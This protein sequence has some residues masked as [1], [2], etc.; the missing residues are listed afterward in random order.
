MAKFALK[1]VQGII[2]RETITLNL[3]KKWHMDKNTLLSVDSGFLFDNESP[4]NLREELGIPNDQMFIGITT[5]NWLS[6]GKQEKYER[7]VAEFSDYAIRTYNAAII[8][9]PQVTVENRKDDDRESNKRA[10]SYMKESERAYILTERYGHGTI[11]AI[12]ENLDYLIG[13]RFHSVI[14]ALTSY[15]PSIAIAYE[16]KTQGIMTDLGLESW[17]VD[18]K[19]VKTQELINLFGQLVI[20]K[21]DY[22][23]QLKKILPSYIARAK[24]SILFVKDL[25]EKIT[26]K[27]MS[28]SKGRKGKVIPLLLLSVSAVLS[29]VTFVKFEQSQ[30]TPFI[31]EI[32]PAESSNASIVKNNPE[33]AVTNEIMMEQISKPIHTIGISAEGGLSKHDISYINNELDQM[34]DLGVTWIRFDIEW[35]HIQ[36]NSQVEYDW[37]NYDVLIAAI[38][39]H[40]LKPLGLVIFTPE[41]ARAADCIGVKCPPHDPSQFAVFM[42]A[43]ASRYKNDIQHWEVGNEPNNVGFWASG[44]DCKAYTS[45]LKA[46]YPAVK[47]ANPNAVIL[48][49]GLAPMPNKAPN[50]GRIEFLDCIYKNG[51][52]NYFDAV[53]D[54]PY[55][56]P[57]LSSEGNVWTQIYLTSPS[58]R[59]IMEKNDDG[60]KRIWLTEVGAPTNGPDENWYVSEAKQALMIQDTIASYKKLDWAGPL[61]WYTLRDEGTSTS[62]IENFFGLKRFDGS[63]KPA[64]DILKEIIRQNI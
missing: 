62:T 39:A 59:S 18:I 4:R 16:Y 32:L 17:V 8:F 5:R 42:A 54:H 47:L 30:Q 38:K 12:Y 46:V 45:I 19:N 53:A 22:R 29:F 48:T 58:L 51:G 35:S 64:Y 1:R 61:F 6:P 27:T 60:S 43:L 37:K 20:K 44:A 9:I 52:K 14:F 24:E 50:M 10:H 40:N 36:M 13:T 41:W 11:K 7:A 2:A 63:K 33:N 3:L 31:K 28:K 55:T 49:G 15:V 21:E 57:K 56:F 26:Q 25:Y 34:V 23:S